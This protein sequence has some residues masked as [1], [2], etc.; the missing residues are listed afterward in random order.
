M[1]RLRLRFRLRP[2][3]AFGAL[4]AVALLLGATLVAPLGSSLH[5]ALADESEVPD[6][7]C[8]G[9][10]NMPTTE[11]PL[12]RLEG[13]LVLLTFMNTWSDHCVKAVVHLN[14]IEGRLGGRGLSVLAATEGMPEDIEPWVEEHGVTFAFATFGALENERLRNAFSVPGDPHA[15]LISPAGAVLWR[16]HPQALKEP[17]IKSFMVGVKAPPARLP[18][19][20]AAQQALLADGKWAAARAALVEASDGLDKVSRQWADGLVMWI[21]D[22]RG[23]WLTDAAALEADGRFW[24]AWDMYTD[25]GTRFEGMEGSDGAAAQAAAIRAN[26]DAAKDLAA[27]DDIAKAR[28]FLAEGKTRQAKLI[29]SRVMKQAKGTVHAE[30]AKALLP[31]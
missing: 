6:V 13:R 14:K 17:A 9:V 19:A 2:C 28:G 31:D 8:T 15:V 25:F 29:L 21:D 27:G 16:G 30:R 4:A 7:A 24:D 3:R 18:E 11:R 12:Q 20:L 26:V 10:V 5:R 1:I 22:R 23:T